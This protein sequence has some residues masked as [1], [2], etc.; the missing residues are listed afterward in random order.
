MSNSYEISFIIPHGNSGLAK[1]QISG[2]ASEQNARDIVRA[3]YG[4]D[5]VITGGRMTEFGGGRNDRDRRDD[6]R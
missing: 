1:D 4:K 3:R 6:R 5:V 2:V